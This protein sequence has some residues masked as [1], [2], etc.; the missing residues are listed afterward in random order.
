[1]ATK[2]LLTIEDYAA[3]EEPPGV[4]YELSEGGADGDAIRQFLHNA[5]RDE[6]SSRL[7]TFANSHKLGSVTGETDMRLAEDVVRRPD[8][9]L[10]AR[11][12][13]RARTSSRLRYTSGRLEPEVRSAKDGGSFE[14]PELLPGFSL[15]PSR[16]SWIFEPL[17][18]PAAVSRTPSTG[19][20]QRLVTPKGV[21]SN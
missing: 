2:T 4:R 1:M 21:K 10:S 11:A 5:L 19:A 14:E 6:F 16:H 17:S 13:C 15:A 20:R 18:T 12:A 9:A 3:L 7:K 8:M